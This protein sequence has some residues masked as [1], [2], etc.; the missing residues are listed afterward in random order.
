M[1]IGLTEKGMLKQNNMKNRSVPQKAT[2]I[3]KPLKLIL[4]ESAKQETFK[5]CFILT[6]KI[7]FYLKIKLK[8]R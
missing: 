2:I 1:K 3:H 6:I 7:N 8:V 5:T 4:P